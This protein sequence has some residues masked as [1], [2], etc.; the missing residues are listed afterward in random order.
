M[1]AYAAA[2]TAPQ[3]LLEALAWA[4]GN[5]G[6]AERIGR[7]GQRLVGR[8][9]SHRGLQCFWYLLLTEYA[10]LQRFTCARERSLPFTRFTLALSPV[11]SFARSAGLGACCGSSCADIKAR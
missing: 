7:R 2:P 8:M 9:L 5:D 3:E 10:K 4:E 11:V 6:E 1:Y